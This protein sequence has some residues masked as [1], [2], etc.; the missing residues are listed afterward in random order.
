M[1][2]KINQYINIESAPV[3]LSFYQTD[4]EKNPEGQPSDGKFLNDL[5]ALVSSLHLQ[6]EFLYAKVVVNR[7]DDEKPFE[8]KYFLGFYF[9]EIKQFL[10]SESRMCKALF[11][12]R[13]K[14]FISSLNIDLTKNNHR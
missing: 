10:N 4:W 2:H 8:H 11:G 14:D 3:P 6:S 12:D 1:Y 13:N 7:G 5:F 9:P